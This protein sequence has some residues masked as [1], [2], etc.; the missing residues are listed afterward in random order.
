MTRPVRACIDLKALVGNLQAAKKLAVGSKVMA[1]VK[2]NAYGHGIV[3]VAQALVDADA[4]AVASIDEALQ[5][6]RAGIQQTIILLEGVFEAS[7]LPEV[8][9]QNFQLVVHTREQLEWLEQSGL[10]GSLTVWLKVDTGMHRL[11]F[12]ASDIDT[13]YQRLSALS[14]V[15]QPPGL[16]SHFAC[17]DEPVHVANDQQATQ[18][19]TLAEHWPGAKS[20]ANSAA[21]SSRQDVRYDW[22]RPGIMLYGSCP[23]LPGNP[24]PVELLPVMSLTT[25][26]IAVEQRMAGQAIGYGG[27]FSCEKP[28]T[29]AVAAIGYGDGYPRHATTGTPVLVNGH[30]CPLIGRVSMDMI[31]LDVSALSDVKAGD[32]VELWGKHLSVDVVANHLGTIAYELLCQVTPRVRREYVQ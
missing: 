9:A 2:A 21:L 4:L 20:L 6:S 19:A 17:A 10:Q 31:T 25:K 1:V 7:E 13:V 23:L 16:L 24:C 22:V 26:L 12:Q 8:L 15:R 18:F 3:E 5:L 30:I 11:G 14:C 27:A 29:V 32:P 28:M